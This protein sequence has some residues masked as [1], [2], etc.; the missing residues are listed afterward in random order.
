MRGEVASACPPPAPRTRRA[1]APRVRQGESRRSEPREGLLP[2]TPPR[3]QPRARERRK[4]NPS[5]TPPEERQG[6]DVVRRREE[7]EER[8][9][10]DGVRG[11]QLAEVTRE[12]RRIARDD[13][14]R[15]RPE[16][17][18]RSPDA[19][20]E[21]RPRRVGHDE[22]RCLLLRRGVVERVLSARHH[23]AGLGQTLP[24]PFGEGEREGGRRAPVDL[25]GG[26]TSG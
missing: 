22:G 20:R 11:V 3:R 25:H 9:L 19:R 15:R 12:R 1:P 5:C 8:Q 7:L 16:R 23:R 26:V 4:T 13:E 21:T 18:E 10:A 2:R 17:E 24:P 14:E 6:L